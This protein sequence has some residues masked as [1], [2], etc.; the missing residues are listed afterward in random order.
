M[1]GFMGRAFDDDGVDCFDL[2]VK[3]VKAGA[4]QTIDKTAK[5]KAQLCLVSMLMPERTILSSNLEV[6]YNICCN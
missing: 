3:N 5:R 2:K 6:S 1:T 4:L